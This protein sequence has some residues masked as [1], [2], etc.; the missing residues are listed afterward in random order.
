[1]ENAN[2]AAITLSPSNPTVTLAGLTS[3]Y[4]T[5]S[6]L[7][8]GST[9]VEAAL[10]G[11][12]KTNF[13]VTNNGT[14]LSPGSSPFDAGIVLASAGEI[15]NTGTIIAPAGIF[16]LGASTGAYIANTGT[17]HAT[18]GDGIY[19]KSHGG[20]DNAGLITAAGTA[21][22][23]TAG[24]TVI[25]QGDIA[26]AAAGIVFANGFANN[27]VLDAGATVSGAIGL[28]GTLA[29]AAGAHSGIFNL[30][31]VQAASTVAVT[32][33][34]SLYG[35]ISGAP[36]IF[37]H[38]TI[39]APISGLGG[40]GETAGDGLDGGGAVYN[41]GSI[42][43][44]IGIASP[45][46]YVYNSGNIQGEN[47]GPF[48]PKSSGI[49][50]LAPGYIINTG[51][52]SAHTGVMLAPSASLYNYGRI[53]GG[54][55]SSG[56]AAVYNDAGGTINGGIRLAAG[57][58]TDY[59]FIKAAAYAVDFRKSAANLLILGSA[60]T[61]TG[62]ANLGGGAIEL[63]AGAKSGT[64][65]AANYNDVSALTIAP[66]AGWTVTGSLPASIAVTNDGTIAA[67][68]DQH[69][70]IA[71]ALS[72]TGTVKLPTT[73]T[74]GGAVSSGQTLDFTGGGET[75]N[76]GDPAAFSG[77]LQ[78]FASSDTIDLTGM[79]F[80]S[81][82]AITF[83]AGILTLTAGSPSLTLT[84]ANPSDFG[85]YQFALFADGTGTGITLAPTQNPAGW[86]HNNPLPTPPAASTL[87]T[88]QP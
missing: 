85:T 58:V 54:V 61:L 69:L 57:T 72:G 78:S 3:A 26:G 37:N 76:L 29:L 42:L 66:A 65:T 74:L 32:S 33:N 36:D 84:F 25:D 83:A 4:G 1:M 79:S 21:I 24:G 20:I 19:D 11:P 80:A 52:I 12:P 77:Q 51:T 68:S 87:I 41:Y 6:A 88:L 56:A 31:L 43:G 30:S 22:A 15:K 50:L 28:Y 39:T 9:H 38:G 53:S 16:I 5:V 44:G 17:I 18:G 67:G 73:L 34:W 60:A 14:I 45:G 10:F 35:S 7:I 70:T 55:R 48:A 86:L 63:L 46:H 8:G 23:L 49:A 82:T 47:G 40:P 27:L 59:G 75:L 71:G 64:F 62:R 2:M 13:N 81:V